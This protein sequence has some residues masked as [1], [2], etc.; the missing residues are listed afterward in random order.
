MEPI[1]TRD[2][3]A[4]AITGRAPDRPLIIVDL[5][6]PRD[7]ERAVG[8]LEGVRLF[9]LDDLRLFQFYLGGPVPLYC[10]RHV[11]ARIRKSYDYRSARQGRIDAFRA[12]AQAEAYGSDSRGLDSSESLA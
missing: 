3:V 4:Q 5:A 1:L 9:G 12:F 10:E 2:L 6:V 11:E 8:E 7:V